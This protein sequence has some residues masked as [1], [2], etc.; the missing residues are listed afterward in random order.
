MS[1]HILYVATQDVAVQG[2]LSSLGMLATSIWPS[3]MSRI[4][5]RKNVDPFLD[6]ITV[7]LYIATRMSTSKL[8]LVFDHQWIKV[9]PLNDIDDT[10]TSYHLIDF[11]LLRSTDTI[12]T[13]VDH[14]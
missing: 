10:G 14:L 8:S 11:V 9:T 3:R 12:S 13:F 1:L 5:P 4:P 2:R 7:T 6:G